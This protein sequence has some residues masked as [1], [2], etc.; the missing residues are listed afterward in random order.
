VDNL[1]YSFAPTP[2]N[3]LLIKP[4]LGSIYDIELKHLAS[5]LEQWSFGVDASIFLDSFFCQ[6]EF[7]EFAR[8]ASERPGRLR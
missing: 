3:G 4:Y 1:V 2:E 8:L 6:R 7:L 5:C